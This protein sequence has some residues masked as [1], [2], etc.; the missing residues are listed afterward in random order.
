[1]SPYASEEFGNLI[2]Y[3]YQSCDDVDEVCWQ[4]RNRSQPRYT[5]YTSRDGHIC[6]RQRQSLLADLTS[7]APARLERLSAW[8]DVV[9]QQVNELQQKS[10]QMST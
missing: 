7:S 4:R 3:L 9:Y 6:I 10:Q 5:R 1:M 2:T 8:A